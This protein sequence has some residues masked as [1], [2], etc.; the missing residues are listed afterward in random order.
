MKHSPSL[1]RKSLPAK[2]LYPLL[3]LAVLTLLIAG[4]SSGVTNTV[5]VPV[6]P[7]QS[8]SPSDVATGKKYADGTYSAT[9]NYGS[10]S[11]L[12][13][14][15]ISLTLKGGIITDATFQGNAQGG[16]SLQYQQVFAAGFRDQVIGKAIDGLF[17]TVVNG[18]SLTPQ[19]FMD[20]V[21]KIQTQ[22]QA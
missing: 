13:S 18:S 20:A 3:S 7:A 2:V 15:D 6:V 14:V 11:G 16:R 22:A 9:G 17:L 19:G 5:Q 21:Q 4:C 10:P 12:E 8:G 1:P